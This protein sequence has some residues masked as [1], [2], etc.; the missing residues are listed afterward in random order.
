[1]ASISDSKEIR[2]S[3]ESLYSCVGFIDLV[4][5]TKNIIV[6]DKIEH[7]RKYYSEF[8]NPISQIIKR[9]EGKIIK[10]IDDGLLFYFPR[11]T[12]SNDNNYHD[13]KSM[14]YF[15]HAIECCFK[16]LDERYK[17]NN[18][19]SKQ[20]L[21]PF[22]YRISLD[23]GVVD[24]ALAGDNNQI[25][26]FGSTINLCSKINTSSLAIP[27]EVIIGDNFYRFLQFYPEIVNNCIFQKNGE[28]KITETIRY[29]SYSL[30][31]K[32]IVTLSQSTNCYNVIYH[33]KEKID[34]NK[35]KKGRKY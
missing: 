26:L 35:K 8:I 7:I 34:T 1:M 9:Y 2:F 16:I 11:I 17:I 5:S 15:K 12:N 30:K 4:D 32:N 23:Y 19:L 18:E 28:C 13:E 24:L 21:P 6:M 33:N 3:N 25:D 20:H 22:N 31:R 14:N 27:N 10:N 29:P